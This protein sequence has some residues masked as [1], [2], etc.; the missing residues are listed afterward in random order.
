MLSDIEN[1]LCSGAEWKSTN[2]C[3]CI[4]LPFLLLD[5]STEMGVWSGSLFILGLAPVWIF[6]PAFSFTPEKCH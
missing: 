5:L 4:Q 6:C 2:F 3:K 1:G